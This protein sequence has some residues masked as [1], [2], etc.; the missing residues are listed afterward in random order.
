MVVLL[1]KGVKIDTPFSGREDVRSERQPV[2]PGN[3]GVFFA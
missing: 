2:E 3:Q 1:K